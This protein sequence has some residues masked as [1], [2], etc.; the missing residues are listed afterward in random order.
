MSPL[1][2]NAS[3]T[4]DVVTVPETL[5]VRDIVALLAARGL[6]RTATFTQPSALSPQP[7]ARSPQPAARHR[8]RRRKASIAS[9]SSTKM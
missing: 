5:P 4:R 3:M 6:V 2:V 8:S 7:S 1:A 9:P